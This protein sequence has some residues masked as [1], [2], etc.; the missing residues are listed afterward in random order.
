M[1][2]GVI[3]TSFLGA[4]LRGGA[5]A[6]VRTGLRDVAD[7]IGAPTDRDIGAP[8]AKGERRW[9]ERRLPTPTAF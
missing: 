7:R 2:D 5:I 1:C 3:G 4:A 6:T 8:F 9:E